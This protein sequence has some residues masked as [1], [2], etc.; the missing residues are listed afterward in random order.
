MVWPSSKVGVCSTTSCATKDNTGAYQADPLCCS[1]R[2]ACIDGNSLQR[3]N[4]TLIQVNIPKDTACNA[5]TVDPTTG[6]SWGR[7][8]C[9]DGCSTQW[10]S[11][12]NDKGGRDCWAGTSQEACSCSKGSARL[13]PA[14]WWGGGKV[15][16]KGKT[17]YAYT[18]CT[19]GPT[20]GETC[21]DYKGDVNPIVSIIVSVVVVVGCCGCCGG[22]A[23]WYFVVRNRRLQQQA[24]YVS[25]PP[26]HYPPQQYPPG[27]YPPQQYPP[28]Q[29]PHGPGQYPQGQFA[30]GQHP[31]GQYPVQFPQGQYPQGQYPPGQYPQGMDPHGHPPGQ[32]QSVQMQMMGP[33]PGQG[34]GPGPGQGA[35]YAAGA[36]PWGG[37]ATAAAVS[38]PVFASGAPQQGYA[39]MT[40]DPSAQAHGNYPVVQAYAIPKQ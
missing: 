15:Q 31:Q 12:P 16:Y 37:Q 20:V 35:V 2:P 7:T 28:Q 5:Y 33:G 36:M 34:P 26:G 17:Y 27:Q 18:C 25:A 30:P 10:C 40:L 3:T 23:Y 39:P 11:S 19:Q 14:G 21:G 13:V 9:Q 38:I 24:V 1:Q 29:Y 4:A 22:G 6:I 32:Q 8:C